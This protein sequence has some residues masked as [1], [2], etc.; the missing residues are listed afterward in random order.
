MACSAV[1]TPRDERHTT[2]ATM[3]DAHRATSLAAMRDVVYRVTN[4]LYNNRM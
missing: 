3:R 1:G 2:R 4:R